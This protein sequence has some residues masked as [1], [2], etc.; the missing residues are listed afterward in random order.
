MLSTACRARSPPISAPTS[1]SIAEFSTDDAAGPGTGTPKDARC[2]TQSRPNAPSS[3]VLPLPGLKPNNCQTASSA[4]LRALGM[5]TQLGALIGVVGDRLEAVGG[6]AKNAIKVDRL[7][8]GFRRTCEQSRLIEVQMKYCGFKICE[9]VLK[10]SIGGKRQRSLKSEAQN[11]M[12]K[13][14]FAAKTLIEIGKFAA[15]A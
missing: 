1:A 10:F 9:A 12:R 4:C 14:L 8:I 6:S 2:P 13:V 5:V 11:Q 7:K 3:S 15:I